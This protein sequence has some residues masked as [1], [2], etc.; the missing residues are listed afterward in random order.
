M[1]GQAVE[2]TN[3]LKMFKQNG[4]DAIDLSDN[5]TAKLHIRYMVGGRP[6]DIDNEML[7]RFQFPE[8]PGALMTFLDQMGSRWNISLFHYRNHGSAFGRVLCGIQVP[9][10]DAKDFQ[11]FLERLGY[12]YWPETDNPV[13][14]TFLL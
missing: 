12:N 8:R 1:D 4:Y 9:D 5:D 3:L 10:G 14:K 11:S 2:K 6:P 13:Y 7:F